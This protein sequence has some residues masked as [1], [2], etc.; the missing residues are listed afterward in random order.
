M[1]H[2]TAPDNLGGHIVPNVT[3]DKDDRIHPP[4]EGNEKSIG[5]LNAGEQVTVLA[6]ANVIREPGIAIIKY[7]GPPAPSPLKAGD[8]ALDY[9]YETFLR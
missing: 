2:Q 1:C 9:G 5:T 7:V 3:I 4:W 6:E 8:V